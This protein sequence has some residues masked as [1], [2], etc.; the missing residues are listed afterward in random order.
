M[1]LIEKL[2]ITSSV[3]V[4]ATSL[5]NEPY[6]YWID[7]KKPMSFANWIS[8]DPNNSNGYEDCLELRYDSDLKWNDCSCDD[9][10]YFACEDEISKMIVFQMRFVFRTLL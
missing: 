7:R 9:R 6:F 3:W 5:G 4:G 2:G 1:T 10:K 8:G